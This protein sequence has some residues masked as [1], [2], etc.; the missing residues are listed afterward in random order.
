MMSLLNLGVRIGLLIVTL[1]GGFGMGGGIFLG[2]VLAGGRKCPFDEG[3]VKVVGN[4]GGGRG[5][6]GGGGCFC[7]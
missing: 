3:V 5:G 4:G 6:S 2:S 7:V 1:G